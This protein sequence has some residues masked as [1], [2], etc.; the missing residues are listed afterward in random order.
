VSAE[1]GID[2]LVKS[3]RRM[4]ALGPVLVITTLVTSIVSSLGA[5][6]IPTIAKDFHVSLS[7]AQWS[8]T[9]ALVS[10]AVSAPVM[11]RLGDG[12]RRKATMIGGLAIV[13]VGGVVAAQATGLVVLVAGRALQGLGLGLAPLAMA[14]ARERLPAHRVAPMIGLLSVS[15]AAGVGA[16]Y[17]ISGLITDGLGLSGAYWFGA[18]VSGVALLCVVVVVPS[19][20]NGP[21][22]HL[23]SFGA[24]LL[25]VALVAV[26]VAVAQGSIWGWGSVKV[27]GLLG[28]GVILFVVWTKQQLHVMSPLVNL[29]LLR[30]PAVLAGNAC[31]MVLGIAMY[32]AL[33]G[34]TE[35]VQHPRSG[36]FGFSASVV[37]TGLTLI[38]LSVLLLLGSRILPILLRHFGMHE[39]L[40]VGCLV[41][42]AACAYFAL[43][44]GGLWESFVMM[45]ALG[46]GLG[47]TFAAIPGLIVRSVPQIETGSAMGFYQVVRYLG[48]AL[49]SA[50]TSTILASR[51][52]TSSGRPTV[53]GYI[54]VFWVAGGIC[55]VAA[56]VAWVLAARGGSALPDQRLSDQAVRLLEET[57]GDGFIDGSEGS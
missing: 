45:G 16:G 49:G 40:S 27:L 18:I 37:V 29:R 56:L 28:A 17:P 35:F 39:L 54:D 9:I 1:A 5:P 50:L 57:D 32:M 51:S 19:K 38:P 23:D 53:D 26:L 14:T 4:A 12:P 15:A 3:Q 7:T 30:H 21:P 44:H 52:S 25:A 47:T 8:L 31:A 2:P 41:V 13:T 46:I 33:S 42:A 48:F 43:C 34:G 55:V 36:G 20:S 11:G 10:G 22:A 24:V 6:L